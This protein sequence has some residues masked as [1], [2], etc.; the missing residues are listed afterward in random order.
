MKRVGL[1]VVLVLVG[2]LVWGGEDVG[3]R[4]ERQFCLGGGDVF[5]ESLSSVCEDGGGNFFVLDGKGAK[6]VKFSAEGQRL[7]SFGNRGQGPGDFVNPH[8]ISMFGK[9]RLVVHEAMNFV[10]IFDVNGAFLERK[11]LQPGLGI[12][13]IGNDRYVGWR[14]TRDGKEL[15]VGRIG[16]EK[17]DRVHF[18][19][20][21]SFSVNVPDETGRKVMFNW[22]TEEYTPFFLFCQDPERYILGVSDRY[23]LKVVDKASGRV[24]VVSRDIKPE[25]I[26]RQARKYF[27][28]LIGAK[29]NF[30][31]RV[32]RE[33]SRRF[34]ISRIICRGYIWLGGKFGR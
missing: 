26:D 6:V 13:Y 25:M 17:A 2:S 3:V 4:I 27:A 20:A 21:E 31:D 29:R 23:E 10:S 33:L 9:D 34:R 19:P 28:G 15:F 14:W 7:L 8:Y 24:T 11:S 1:I 18:I 22:F 30:P 12:F 16:T 32:K 5:F